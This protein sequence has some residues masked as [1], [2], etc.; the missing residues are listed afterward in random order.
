MDKNYEHLLQEVRDLHN[1]YSEMVEGRREAVRSMREKIKEIRSITNSCNKELNGIERYYA[2]RDYYVSDYKLVMNLLLRL[3]NSNEERYAMKEINTIGYY[4]LVDGKKKYQ[5]KVYFISEKSFIDK[6][7]DH[8]YYLDEFKRMASFA[9]N[10]GYSMMVIT[11]NLFEPNIKPRKEDVKCDSIFD[12]RNGGILGNITCYIN[13]VE[14][15]ENID[16]LVNY[17]NI[18]G[19]D[20]SN[21][22]EDT[23]FEIISNVNKTQ[24][25]STK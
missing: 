17:I 22:D 12:F 24:K 11:S 10:R 4:D 13:S 14:L 7:E 19:P 2:Y 21:I 18:N 16:K 1:G 25:T 23:L 9:I 3:A 20:F 8:V 6:L 5:S 15:H